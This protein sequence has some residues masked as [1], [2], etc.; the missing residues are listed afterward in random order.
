MAVHGHFHSAYQR[1]PIIS[2]TLVHG[3][4][5]ARIPLDF[6]VDTGADR[7]LLVPEH[8]ELL[9]ISSEHL[10]SVPNP[11]Y[12]LAGPV[13]CDSLPGCALVFV[14]RDDN[15]LAIHGV[16]VWFLRNKKTK[17][18]EF[19]GEGC[20]PSILGRDVLEK[21]ALSYCPQRDQLLL[22]DRTA[23]YSDLVAAE[24]GEAPL[25]GLTL[26]AIQHNLTALNKE[27]ALL[28]KQTRVALKRLEST[29][30][31]E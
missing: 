14:D 9:G 25:G 26:D 24:F 3:C 29:G 28:H 2:A 22:T 23:Q 16:D 4:V 21:L 8:Q 10:V 15:P 12:T 18:K 27:M 1:R 17:W 11:I 20:V 30:R 6:M 19:M 13:Q 31:G 7:T 5:N